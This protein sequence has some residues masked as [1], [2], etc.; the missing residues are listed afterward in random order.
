MTY[1]IV[2][3]QDTIEFEFEKYTGIAVC[4]S[5][6]ADSATLFYCLAEYITVENLDIKLYPITISSKNDLVAAHAGTLVVNFV[7]KRFPNVF[8]E[9]IC[10][11]ITLS[12]DFKAPTAY[13]IIEDMYF[14]GQ[15]QAYIEGVTRNPDNT[16]KFNP[17]AYHH[18]P[19]EKFREV[20]IPKVKTHQSGLLRIRPFAGINKKGVCEITDQKKIT[21]RILLMTRSCTDGLQFRCNTCWWCRERQ[22]GFSIPRQ[23][24][25]RI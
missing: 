1:K 17:P 4:L 21:A 22:W 5:G 24:H 23:Y 8:I 16:F 11:S 10:K 9:H 19:A 18:V 15:V 14:K 6:G 20:H 12:G 2:T 7:K 13:R 25:H 3:S